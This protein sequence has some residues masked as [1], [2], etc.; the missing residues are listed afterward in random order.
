MTGVVDEL[1]SLLVG[2]PF[3]GAKPILLASADAEDDDF[4]ARMMGER[5]KGVQVAVADASAV[6]EPSGSERDVVTM[7]VEVLV[8]AQTADG[9]FRTYAELHE[10][11]RA[12][13]RENP[14]LNGAV[15]EAVLADTEMVGHYNSPRTLLSGSVQLRYEA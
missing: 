8:A 15:I 10:W 11:L 5:V 14:T 9:Q 3:A 13:F 6:V 7:T 1:E 12:R 2:A 4:A